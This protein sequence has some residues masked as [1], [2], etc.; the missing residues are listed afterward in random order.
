MFFGGRVFISQTILFKLLKI[1][2]LIPYF[3]AQFSIP[4][5]CAIIP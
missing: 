3:S 2:G 1:A 4:K 5:I